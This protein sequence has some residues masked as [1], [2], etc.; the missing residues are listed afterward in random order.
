VWVRVGGRKSGSAVATSVMGIG[1]GVVRGV[2]EFT[3]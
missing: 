2:E 1:V 3:L